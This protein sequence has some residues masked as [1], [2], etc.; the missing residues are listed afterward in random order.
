[1]RKLFFVALAVMALGNSAQ[2]ALILHVQDVTVSTSTSAQ[3]VRFDLFLEETEGTEVAV[4]SY[5]IPL[6]LNPLGPL[7]F[8]DRQPSTSNHPSLFTDTPRPANATNLPD[9]QYVF[10]KDF[11]L[12]DDF[13]TLDDDG[14]EVTAEAPVENNVRDGLFSVIVNIPANTVGTFTVTVDEDGGAFE[15]ADKNGVAIPVTVDN[16]MITVL[17]V[18]E[19]STLALGLLA[20]PLLARR[21]RA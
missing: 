20:L 17:P 14:L 19:P 4:T 21:R 1:M 16:G 11:F 15:I 9:D 12:I 7:D 2:A 6:R 3:T 5:D 8:V 10:P 13:K 18:P